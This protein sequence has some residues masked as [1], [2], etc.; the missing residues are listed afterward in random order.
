MAGEKLESFRFGRG[1]E[2][3]VL[4]TLAQSPSY[5]YEIRRRLEAFGYE[6]A[7]SDPGALY[8]LLRDME[9]AG[10]IAS[11]WEVG[12]TGPARR[13]YT[14]SEQGR[15]DLARAARRM[16]QVKLRAE[17]FLAEYDRF[18]SESPAREPEPARAGTGR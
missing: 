9:A 2:A 15:G 4:L 12:A 6:R 11:R 13:Y 5:G 17:R 7:T 16:A 1:A 18:N 10:S 3:F 14:L 8:R